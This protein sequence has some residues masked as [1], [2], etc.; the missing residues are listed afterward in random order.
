MTRWLSRHQVSVLWRLNVICSCKMQGSFVDVSFFNES[1][2]PENLSETWILM[3]WC[4]IELWVQV[5]SIVFESNH[6]FVFCC[7]LL[8]FEH[9]LTCCNLARLKMF[10]YNLIWF[11]FQTMRIIHFGTFFCKLRGYSLWLHVAFKCFS[12]SRGALVS[13]SSGDIAL[14]RFCRVHP[15]THTRPWIY[16]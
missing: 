14:W 13:G 12:L 9:Q 1:R 2:Q 3:V 5:V 4:W 10:T 7:S 16:F 15:H 8:L 6:D 11:L